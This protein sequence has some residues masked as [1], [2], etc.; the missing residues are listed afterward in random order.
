MK[1]KR[2]T[3]GHKEKFGGDGCICSL[4]CGDG[5]MVVYICQNI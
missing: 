2:G 4:D 5:V 3:Q 1:W